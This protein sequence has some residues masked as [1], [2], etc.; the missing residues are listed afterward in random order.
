MFISFPPFVKNKLKL[1]TTLPEYD[2]LLTYITW[3]GPDKYKKLTLNNN[4]IAT[5]V[6]PE[7]LRTPHVTKIKPALNC[8]VDKYYNPFPDYSRVAS[9]IKSLMLIGLVFIIGKIS[10]SRHPDL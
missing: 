8:I 9:F 1:D 2:P 6:D 5:L 7:Q 10:Q 3:N 4:R